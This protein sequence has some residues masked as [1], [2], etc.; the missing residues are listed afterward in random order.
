SS[1][2]VRDLYEQV[3]GKTLDSKTL[4]RISVVVTV[5]VAALGLVLAI[6]SPSAIMTI[7]A[8]ATGLL[9]ASF[10]MVV[11]GGIYTRKLTSQG[12]L[13]SMLA[14]FFGTLLSYPGVIVSQN[15]LN[16]HSFIWGL[17]ASIVA[18]VLVTMLTR[19]VDVPEMTEALDA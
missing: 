7:S 2:F 18:G 17:L 5:V 13:A 8:A 19:E 15:I 4:L 14:G 3:M 9:G 6:N 1:A 16:M 11:V 10:F 12:A